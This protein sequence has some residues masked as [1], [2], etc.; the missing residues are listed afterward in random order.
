MYVFRAGKPSSKGYR[1]AMKM[2]GTTPE[3][4][5][6]VGDQI[7]TDVWGANNA[8]IDTILTK[9][10]DPREEIQIVLKRRLEWL[11]LKAYHAKKKTAEEKK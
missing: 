1:E 5:L 11:V 4:T 2:M 3:T 6:F 8:G 9:P 7:F 10:I